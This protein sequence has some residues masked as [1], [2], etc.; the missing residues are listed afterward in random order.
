MLVSTN[1]LLRGSDTF[2]FPFA[3]LG[4]R[5]PEAGRSAYAGCVP[6]PHRPIPA[7]LV[8]G[9]PDTTSPRPDVET[10]RLLA[11]NLR[12]ALNGRSLRAAKDATGVDHSTIADIL[13][14]RAW[15]DLHTIAS[16][17]AGLHADL[18]PTGIARRAAARQ[19]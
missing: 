17:E 7:A 15:P 10:A 11:V 18:W 8:D 5:Q 19:P 6:R 3:R 4:R 16:L 9:W 13:N 14:G 2:P 12:T 1:S